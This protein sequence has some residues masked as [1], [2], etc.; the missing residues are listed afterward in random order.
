MDT[1]GHN[2][3]PDAKAIPVEATKTRPERAVL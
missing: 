1:N 3:R 2:R